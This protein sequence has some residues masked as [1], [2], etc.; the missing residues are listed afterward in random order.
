MVDESETDWPPPVATEPP[1]VAATIQHKRDPQAVY[2][3][4]FAFVM[5]LLAFAPYIAP[6]LFGL[7]ILFTPISGWAG[8]IGGC[9]AFK[10]LWGRLAFYISIAN[11]ILFLVGLSQFHVN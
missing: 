10:S 9:L 4:A 2:V 5:A 11:F 1:E 3:G 8:F 6:W 7:S